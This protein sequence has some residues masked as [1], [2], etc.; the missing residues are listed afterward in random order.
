[1]ARQKT[2]KKPPKRPA[3]CGRGPIALV[4][5]LVLLIGGFFGWMTLS[6]RIT[7][8]RYAD[9]YLPD[10]PPAFSGATVLYVSDLNIR[11]PGDAAACRRLMG[12]LGQLRPDI[13]VLGGD[14]TAPTLLDSLN[15]DEA[16]DSAHALEFVPCL[17]N[18]PARLGKFAVAGE[19]DDPALLAPAFE[20]AGVQLLS[21]G[22][23]QLEQGGDMLVIAGMSDASR[24]DTNYEKI[25]AYF[26]GDECVIAVAHNPAAYV[27]IRVAE[28][29]SG[30]A[31]ADMV[32]SGH[33]LGGQIRLFGR[34][35][36]TMPEAEARCLAGWY[37]GDDLP[38]LVSQ[39][40]GCRGPM[41]RLG[42]GSEVWM[43]TLRRPLERGELLQGG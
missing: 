43:I 29:R 9:V 34:T 35:L 36:R 37:Y 2:Q 26:S 4:L 15:G 18:F 16:G 13:L 23:V 31:W 21:D 32:L 20:Q 7:R 25:G 28:A 33:N 11:T 3:R 14:Y 22:C 24:G 5:A 1:M 8:V 6:A 39:G 40:V 41:L 10:L 38:M 42:T 12:T 19:G 17:A 27:G 30:G